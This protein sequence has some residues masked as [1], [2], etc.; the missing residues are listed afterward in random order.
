MSKTQLI[1]LLDSSMVLCIGL[2]GEC[3]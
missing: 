2:C 1:N 3:W